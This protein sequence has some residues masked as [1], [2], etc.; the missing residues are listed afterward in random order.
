MYTVLYMLNA[1]LNFADCLS[2]RFSTF[3]S[4]FRTLLCTHGFY[5]K[6]A[7][8]RR[9]LLSDIF[10]SMPNGG[11]ALMYSDQHSGNIG[12]HVHVLCLWSNKSIFASQWSIRYGLKARPTFLYTWQGSY[13]GNTEYLQYMYM[14]MRFAAGFL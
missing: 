8:P 12:L 10:N 4:L 9:T 14:N 2:I 6:T 11:F 7:G 3:I 1:V 13:H 5:L